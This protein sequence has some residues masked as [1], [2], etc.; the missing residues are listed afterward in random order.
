MTESTAITHRLKFDLVPDDDRLLP[1]RLVCGPQVV[2]GRN[3][4]ECDLVTWF[5]PR[6]TDN[7]QQTLRLSQVH[8]YLEHEHSSLRIRDADSAAGTSWNQL[9][10]PLGEGQSSRIGPE[11]R[12]TLGKH[13]HV[14]VTWHSGCA[15]L[16][17]IGTE[18]AFR[19][20]VWMIGARCAFRIDTDKSSWLVPDESGEVIF[21]ARNGALWCNDLKLTPGVKLPC[22]LSVA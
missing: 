21:I 5:L 9:P 4:E 12:L 7:D 15:T 13:F 17:P 10:V 2:I 20:C 16:H 19:H 6:N 1:V 11:G 3:K 8:C 18:P 22:G 14:S